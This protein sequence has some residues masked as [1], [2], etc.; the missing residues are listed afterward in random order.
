MTRHHAALGWM[1]SLFLLAACEPIN[2]G[3]AAPPESTPCP[4]GR[5]GPAMAPALVP[6]SSSYCID[7][8]E[9]TQAH[10]AAF[11][12]DAAANPPSQVAECAW[13][14][15]LE[16]RTDERSTGED[17][18]TVWG[19]CNPDAWD[20]VA[21]ADRPVVCVDWCDAAAYCTWAGKR[22]CGKVG[23][24]GLDNATA[25]PWN[26]LKSQWYNACSDSGLFKYPYGDTYR[27]DVCN[28][29]DAEEG[30]TRDVTT[31]PEVSG[32]HGV[33]A[34]YADLYDMSGNVAE[35]EDGC[36][37]NPNNDNLEQDFCYVRGGS[38]KEDGQ[39]E[40]PCLGAI[41]GY[42]RSDKSNAYVGF[43]CCG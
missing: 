18:E 17:G 21:K 35:W 10:Y 38:Y 13:N 22:L 41:T 28:G 8:T 40:L 36:Q 37:N 24:G 9:V 32:C 43:R 23:G 5:P 12:A 15:D 14:D 1:G 3:G 30:R 42:Y 11:L 25:D 34:P 20:P 2:D 6:P 31:D 26:F 39:D 7:V 27:P 19:D 16:P 33:Y 4:E 29:F